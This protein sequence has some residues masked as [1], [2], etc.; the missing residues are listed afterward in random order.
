MASRPYEPELQCGGHQAPQHG[1]PDRGEPATIINISAAC[2]VMIMRAMISEAHFDIVQHACAEHVIGTAEQTYNVR[3]ELYSCIQYCTS[4]LSQE[5]MH[6]CTQDRSTPTYT[7]VACCACCRSSQEQ[8]FILVIATCLPSA[9]ARAQSGSQ[10]C[11]AVLCAI[12]KPA[13]MKRR[14]RR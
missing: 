12:G 6:A 9:A 1:G 4:C 14:R 3:V 5:A 2:N 10:T 13:R 8:T 7:C 11:A